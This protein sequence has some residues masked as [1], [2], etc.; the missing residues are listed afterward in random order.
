MSHIRQFSDTLNNETLAANQQVQ[1]SKVIISGEQPDNDWVTSKADGEAFSTTSTLG[2]GGVFTSNWIDTDGWVGIEV[3]ISSDQL[4]APDGIHLQFTDDVQAGT[5]IVRKTLSYEFT[6]EDLARGSLIFRQ[7]TFLDGFRIVYTN[8]SVTQTTF[9][10]AAQLRTKIQQSSSLSLESPVNADIITETSRVITAGKD[11]MNNYVNSRSTGTA[12]ITTTP[13]GGSSTFD[14]GILDTSGFTQLQNYF[15]ADTDGTF[16]AEAYSDSAGTDI[17]RTFSVP[18]TAGDGLRFLSSPTFG[19]YIRYRY[20]NSSTP[21]TDF[22]FEVRFL[23]QS[24]HGQM[25]GLEDFITPTMVANLGRNVIVG[26]DTG[27]NYQNVIVNPQG[28]LITGNFNTQVALGNINGISGNVKFGRS[29]D[30]QAATGVVDVWNSLSLYT[31]QPTGAAETVEAFSDNAGDTQ[32]ITI[33]GLDASFNEQSESLVLSGLTPVTSINTYSRVFRVTV[34]TPPINAGEITVRHSTTTAN[35]FALVAAGRGQSTIGAFT[36]PANKTAV[37]ESIYITMARTNGSAGSA[38]VT[39]RARIP[40]G[41]YRA[42]RNYEISDS[43][44][45]QPNNQV[46]I[47][48]PAQT[49]VVVRVESV[50]D[51]NTFVTAEIDY[52]LIDN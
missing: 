47:T 11:P 31:G 14:T 6:A 9:Y 49:D 45:A 7:G 18:Y 19:N 39:L 25:L 4:S 1:L 43:Q 51:N 24:L 46:P 29:D 30:I 48:L 38:N 2:V 20:I 36:V 41:V 33:A 42:I 13:L 21:Q 27:N 44:P 52:L 40:G 32:T 16:T 17:I 5:P 23:V 3:F 34:D 26:K 12:V 10:L 35:V 50:S 15:R 37:L 22:Y 28:A 8:G